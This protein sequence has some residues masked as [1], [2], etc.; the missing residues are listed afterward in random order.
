MTAL[1]IPNVIFRN[2]QQSIQLQRRTVIAMT[3]NLPDTP[4][5]TLGVASAINSLPQSAAGS[6][7]QAGR[8]KKIQRMADSE[9][10]PYRRIAQGVCIDVERERHGNNCTGTAATCDTVHVTTVAIGVIRGIGA[11]L[12]VICQGTGVIRLVRLLHRLLPVL[13]AYR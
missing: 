3:Y 2:A 5:A 8:S 6:L 7:A 4:G 11:R 12:D 13:A 1:N 10:I 9:V